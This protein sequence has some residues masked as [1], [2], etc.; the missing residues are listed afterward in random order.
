MF[1]ILYSCCNFL[2]VET[3]QLSIL[4]LK[5]KDL[6]E[7]P[8]KCQRVHWYFCQRS[9]PFSYSFPL[10]PPT[11]GLPALSFS[12]SSLTLIG[13]LAVITYTVSWD[14]RQVVNVSRVQW[15]YIWPIIKTHHPMAWF[16]NRVQ[17]KLIETC[18]LMEMC[19]RLNRIA[20]LLSDLPNKIFRWICQAW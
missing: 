16:P 2:N 15:R 5:Y 11:D 12:I 20:S 8:S 19:W 4:S 3:S 10:F 1:L 14:S 9:M 7:I 13:M 18:H 6:T 17:I